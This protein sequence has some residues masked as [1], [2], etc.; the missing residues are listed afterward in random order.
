M[1]YADADRF[2][3]MALVITGLT[4]TAVGGLWGT[5]W[6]RRSRAGYASVLAL[7]AAAAVP[8]SF[9]AFLIPD[10][11]WAKVSLVAAMFL[12]FL[13]TGPVN[14]LILETV[15]VGQRAAAMA[16]SIFAIHLGGDLWSP[17]LVGWLSSRLGDLREAL[18]LTL[19][20][21]IVLCAVFWG[22]LAV[23]QRGNRVERVV[24]NA[25]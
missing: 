20:F 7:S 13:S 21:A 4:A 11:L 19:P 25:L 6:Q 10:L 5:A 3:G 9:A 8:V 14:T 15:P 22:W 23:A 18:V 12:L 17:Q 1:K 24:P 2:F 16:A